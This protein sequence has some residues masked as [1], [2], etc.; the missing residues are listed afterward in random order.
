MS[1]SSD[2]HDLLINLAAWGIGLGL[3]LGYTYFKRRYDRR[4]LKKSI[5]EFFGQ[6][7]NFLIIHSA[8]NDNGEWNYPATDTKAARRLATMFEAAGLREGEHFHIG[9]AKWVNDPLHPAFRLE[10]N[11]L[12]LLCGPARN[13]I[14]RRFVSAESGHKYYMTFDETDPNKTINVLMDRTGTRFRSSRE[15]SPRTN[16]EHYDQALVS[17]FP[18]PGD[19]SFRVVLLAGIH[20]TGTVAAAEQVSDTS[21]LKDIIAKHTDGTTIVCRLDVVY[22][23]KDIETPC[24][25]KV[26]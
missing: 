14:F 24:D 11:N 4:S 15:G 19:A 17:S 23:P 25:V 10:A 6:G 12:V 8:I 18:N 2:L 13:G 21:K 26:M 22:D 20:G 5:R 9:P 16:G 3:G 7:K 1:W